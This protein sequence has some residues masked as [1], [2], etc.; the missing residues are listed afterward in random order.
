MTA[1]SDASKP[2][3]PGGCGASGGYKLTEEL[4]VEAWNTRALLAEQA[5]EPKA[6]DAPS[7]DELKDLAHSAYEEAMSFGLSVDT[8]LRYFKGIRNRAAIAT[9]RKAP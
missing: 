3:G 9:E 5:Q 7:D 4:A 8:F 2:D 6:E 1:L